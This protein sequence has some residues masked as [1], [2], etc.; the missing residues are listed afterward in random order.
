MLDRP[1]DPLAQ[2]DELGHAAHLL[3]QLLPGVGREGDLLVQDDAS[4]PGAHDQ[5][6]V[7][8]EHRLVDVVRD[9]QDRAV[10]GPLQGEQIGL[11]PGAGDRVERAEG[12]VHE[13]DLG[14]VRQHPGD[15]R[16]LLHAAGELVGPLVAE[17]AEAHQLE[18]LLRALG[19]LLLGDAADPHAQRHVLAH[20]EPRVEVRLLEDDAA[21]RARAGDRLAGAAGGPAGGREEA[22]DDLEQRRLPAARGADDADELPAGDVQVGLGERVDDLAAVGDVALGDPLEGDQRLGGG[23]RR[24]HRET[25][26]IASG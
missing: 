15:L 18:V 26:S 7:P 8:Q 14:V 12:L 9:E 10:L 6:P 20:R 1:G 13:H 11:E 25:S 3:A 4:G 16:P 23:R 24:A 19:A 2:L 21:P 5:H 17:V 22:G